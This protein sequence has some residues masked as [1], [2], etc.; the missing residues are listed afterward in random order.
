M[1]FPAVLGNS[2]DEP[3]KVDTKEKQNIIAGWAPATAT[4]TV[5]MTV[6][7]SL[8]LIPGTMDGVIG[9]LHVL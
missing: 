2:G 1:E 4:A 7:G 5:M 6:M 9:P 3:N 8:R